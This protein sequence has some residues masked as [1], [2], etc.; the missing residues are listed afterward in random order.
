[1]HELSLATSMLTIAQHHVPPGSVLRAV[2]LVAG[3]MRAINPE[4][5]QFAWRAALAAARVGEVHLQLEVLPWTLRCPECGCEWD[6]PQLECRCAACGANRAFPVG[7][8]ELQVMSI[9]VDDEHSTLG[10]ESCA[11]SPSSRT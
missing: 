1:M 9:R 2:R 6:S 5:M 10:A 3:P 8:D 4:A 7:G 11:R